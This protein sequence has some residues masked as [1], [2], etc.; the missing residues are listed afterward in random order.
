MLVEWLAMSSAA[1]TAIRTDS[2][3]SKKRLK[4]NYKNITTPTNVGSLN[5][6]SN[7][8]PMQKINDLNVISGLVIVRSVDYDLTVRLSI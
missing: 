1:D 3:G 4:M 7:E 2:F 8:T 5:G 6:L